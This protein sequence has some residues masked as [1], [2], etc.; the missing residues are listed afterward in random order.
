MRVRHLAS[1]V[2]IWA[3]AKLNLF[4]EVLAK[5]P[6][7]FHEIETLMCP[8]DL[9]DTL[10]FEPLGPGPIEFSAALAAHRASRSAAL[11]TG[12][13][14]LIV[15]ALER[16][17]QRYGIERGAR[18]RLHKRIP[19]EAGLAGGSSD[20]AAALVAANLGWQLRLAHEELALVAAELGS[21]VAFFLHG[22]PAI[23]RGRGERIEPLEPR[24]L[25]QVV[26][27]KPPEGLSTAAVYRA[28][29]PSERPRGAQQLADALRQGRWDQVAAA[30][31]NDLQAPAAGLSPWIDRILTAL[32]G[33]DVVARQMTGSGSACFA[34]CRSTNQARTIAGRLRSQQW[35]EV[36]VVRMNC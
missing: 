21:D 35:G 30:M 2:Q 18:V 4:L 24:G 8:I 6:D 25:M 28:C 26:V 10:E 31:H 9:G 5:R 17:R 32:R 19:L 3:P 22:R 16:L 27:V 23:C 12:A 7:G 33:E 29:V 15:Q 1:G 20:A 34:I 11:P 14:N 36:S 13:D